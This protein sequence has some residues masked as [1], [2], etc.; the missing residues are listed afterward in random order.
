[1]LAEDDLGGRVGYCN[2][3]VSP[4]HRYPEDVLA[5][6]AL[7]EEDRDI[8]RFLWREPGSDDPPKAYR[9]TR[10]CFGLTCSPYVAIQMIYLN[11]ER[12]QAEFIGGTHRDL[13]QHVR[14]RPSCE[15]CCTGIALAKRL[16]GEATRLLGKGGFQHAKWASN[17][18][19]VVKDVLAEDQE[20]SAR[21]RLW[22]TLRI[23]WQREADVLTFCPPQKIV[24]EIS[25]MKRPLF[26]THL[27]AWRHTR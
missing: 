3:T 18:P 14:G 17:L 1:M 22:K 20:S 11:A 23:L 7:H 26:T 10:V 16:A 6:V 5:R 12:H 2:P 4:E 25:D 19:D 21:G 24:T 27:D 9:L 13:A 8:C 15:L